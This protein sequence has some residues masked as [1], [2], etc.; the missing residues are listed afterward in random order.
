MTRMVDPQEV[1]AHMPPGMAIYGRV[2]RPTPCT[3]FFVREETRIVK[4]FHDPIVK[5]RPGAFY[6]PDIVLIVVMFQVGGNAD[7]IFE[8]WFNY[9]AGESMG[10]I[11]FE[12]LGTQENIGFHFYGDNGRRIKSVAIK[13]SLKDFFISATEGAQKVVPWSMPAFDS[14]RDK[15]Y[16]NYPTPGVLWDHLGAAV[17]Q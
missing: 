9:Y 10:K 8:T 3:D 16:K 11:A 2:F 4:G 12:D 1:I 5:L 15:L 17:I 6:H 13:N 7:Q 14:A